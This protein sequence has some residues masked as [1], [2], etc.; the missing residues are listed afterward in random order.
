MKSPTVVVAISYVLAAINFI[1]NHPPWGLLDERF[2]LAVNASAVIVGT[3][4]FLL[5]CAVA[6]F[7]FWRF[8]LKAWPIIL[9][10]PFALA[11][12]GGMAALCVFARACV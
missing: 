7:A 6:T 4:S 9:A 12:A 11:T 1:V 5:R 2:L 3:V 10:A 8:R